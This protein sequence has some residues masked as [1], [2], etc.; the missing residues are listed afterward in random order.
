MQPVGGAHDSENHA[1]DDQEIN[2]RVQE[3]SVSN[4]RRACCFGGS[5]VWIR[6]AVEA[7]EEVLEIN[8]SKNQADRGHQNI[9]DERGDDGTE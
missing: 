8:F 5:K 9:V 1:G 4:G 3:L 7:E 6:V 2:D